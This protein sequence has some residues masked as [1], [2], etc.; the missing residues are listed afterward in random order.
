MTG[1][2]SLGK[3]NIKVVRH[4][5]GH[6]IDCCIDERKGLIEIVHGSCKTV[7]KVKPGPIGIEF[8]KKQIDSRE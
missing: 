6:G 7:L 2:S 1:Y 5:E 8:M 4:P 3:R